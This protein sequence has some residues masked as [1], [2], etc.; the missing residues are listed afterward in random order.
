LIS[1]GS[2]TFFNIVL[3][4]L[5]V[6]PLGLRYLGASILS[7]SVCIACNF[8]LQRVWAFDGAG[9]SVLKQLPQFVAVNLFGL[10]LNTAML[11]MLVETTGVPVVLCQAMSSLAICGLSFLAYRRIFFRPPLQPKAAFPRGSVRVG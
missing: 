7:Y 5:F 2:A 6:G 3:L 11:Y 8:A 4:W 1:G 10:M 9:G